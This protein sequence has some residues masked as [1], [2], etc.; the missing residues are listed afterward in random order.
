[1][2]QNDKGFPTSCDHVLESCDFL[3]DCIAGWDWKTSGTSKQ[4]RKVCIAAWLHAYSRPVF[5]VIANDKGRFKGLSDPSFS[6]I[7]LMLLCSTV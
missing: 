6:Y 5:R 1:M 7:A 4:V 2:K 3:R